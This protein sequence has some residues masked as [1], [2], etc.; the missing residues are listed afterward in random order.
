MSFE[1]GP[2]LPCLDLLVFDPGESSFRLRKCALRIGNRLGQILA[3]CLC[4]TDLLGQFGALTH[5]IR[6]QAFEIGKIG[7]QLLSSR[8]KLV[9]PRLR[10]LDP[11]GPAFEIGLQRLRLTARRR[12]PITKGRVLRF[13]FSMGEPCAL[14]RILGIRKLA[15]ST[16][17]RRSRLAPDVVFF[18]KAP[19]EISPI[20]FQPCHLRFDLRAFDRPFLGKRRPTP[21]IGT[22][23]LKLFLRIEHELSSR[24][25]LGAR[26]SLLGRRRF[27]RLLGLTFRS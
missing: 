12:M 23:L 24:R 16:F 19:I 22:I 21:L 10:R 27:V 25:R 15:D 14:Q 11:G 9:F 7:D 17:E 3:L 20:T 5:Q 8:E 13:G 18:G 4:S 26:C 6:R 1:P 2:T